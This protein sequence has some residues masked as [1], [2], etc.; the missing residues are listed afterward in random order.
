V[1]E[2]EH[3]QE[4]ARLVIGQRHGDPGRPVSADEAQA[5]ASCAGKLVL[6]QASGLAGGTDNVAD[7][8]GAEVSS[9]HNIS[10]SGIYL[11]FQKSVCKTFPIRKL[12]SSRSLQNRNIPARE[13]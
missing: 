8:G 5:D 12:I 4:I 7:F 1:G 13:T 10:R 9:D 6:P 2:R 11:G 3:D